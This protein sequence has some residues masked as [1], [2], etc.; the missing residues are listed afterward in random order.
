[1]TRKVEEEV[2]RLEIEVGGDKFKERMAFKKVTQR[3]RAGWTPLCYAVVGGDPERLGLPTKS[4]KNMNL[5]VEAWKTSFLQL[6]W[7][8]ASGILHMDVKCESKRC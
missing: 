6:N 5:K 7:Q 2:Q 1:M 3:D 8:I 4:I